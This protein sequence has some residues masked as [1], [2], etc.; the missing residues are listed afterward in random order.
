MIHRSLLGRHYE[1]VNSSG[2]HSQLL[3]PITPQKDVLRDLH[4]GV[5]GRHLGIDK[6]LARL[7]ERYYWPVYTQDVKDW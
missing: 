7:Q 5:M 3:V 2:C 6:N 4:E 1:Q